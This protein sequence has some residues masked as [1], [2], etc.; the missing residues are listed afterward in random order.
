MSVFDGDVV[1]FADGQLIDGVNVTAVTIV[2]PGQAFEPVVGNC[3][4][5]MSFEVK[6]EDV[7]LWPPVLWHM[8]MWGNGREWVLLIDEM[9]PDEQGDAIEVSMLGNVIGGPVMS[10]GRFWSKGER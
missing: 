9:V 2:D 1:V 3:T 10:D 5:E 7:P 8:S 6:A 4:V